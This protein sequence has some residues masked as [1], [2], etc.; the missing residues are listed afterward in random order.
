M[1]SFDR[2]F[3]MFVRGAID[4]GLYSKP[5]DNGIDLPERNACL[6]H[7]PRTWVHSEKEALNRFGCEVLDVFLVGRPCILQW[8][9]DMRDRSGELKLS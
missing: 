8:V 6:G 5:V 3:G 4:F 7:A 9:V 2:A 1:K